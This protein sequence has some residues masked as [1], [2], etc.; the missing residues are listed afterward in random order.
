[1]TDE[2]CINFCA[3]KGYIYAGTEYS[4]ECCELALFFPF[5]F[6]FITGEAVCCCASA[7][8]TAAFDVSMWVSN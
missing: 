1:M 5:L 7:R 6:G 3:G 2:S 8:V 4:A